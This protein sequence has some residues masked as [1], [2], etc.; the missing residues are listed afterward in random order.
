M[1]ILSLHSLMN[2]INIFYANDENHFYGFHMYTDGTV[3]RMFL[4]FWY[5]LTCAFHALCDNRRTL[6]YTNKGDIYGS[7]L[8]QI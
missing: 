3:Y 7:S 5:P 2:I 8:W 1:K 4:R 6:P